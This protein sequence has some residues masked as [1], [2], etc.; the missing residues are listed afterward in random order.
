MQLYIYYLFICMCNGCH[1]FH[2]SLLLLHVFTFTCLHSGLWKWLV[3]YV[4]F[5][6][7]SIGCSLYA[8]YVCYG[9]FMNSLGLAFA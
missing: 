1:P 9:L 5:P 6:I 8:L 7:H 4:Y 3:D 2:V